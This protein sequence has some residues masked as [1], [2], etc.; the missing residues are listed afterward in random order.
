MELMKRKLCFKITA[1]LGNSK[2]QRCSWQERKKKLR[3]GPLFKKAHEG[4]EEGK[5][6]KTRKSFVRI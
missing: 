5:T 6:E 3:W 2:R 4:K 1:K